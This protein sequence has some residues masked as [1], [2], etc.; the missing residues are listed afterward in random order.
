M[1][2]LYRLHYTQMHILVWRLAY[3]FSFRTIRCRYTRNACKFVDK[4]GYLGKTCT[5][6]ETDKQDVQ[7]CSR[8]YLLEGTHNAKFAW[9]YKIAMDL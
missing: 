2:V 4:P 5:S 6:R 7:P 1:R 9:K 8:Y 3:E